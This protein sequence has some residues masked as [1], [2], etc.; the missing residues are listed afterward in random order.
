[1]HGSTA[2]VRLSAAWGGLGDGA[3]VGPGEGVGEAGEVEGQVVFL[4]QTEEFALPP[5]APGGFAPGRA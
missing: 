4:S 2:G 1:V 3:V 5:G